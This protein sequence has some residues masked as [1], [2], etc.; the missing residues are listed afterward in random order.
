MNTNSTDFACLVTGFL[1]DYLPLQRSYS[2][3]TILSYRDTL[4]LFLRFLSE[5]KGISPGSFYVK[6]FRRELVIEFLEWYR[7][8]GASISAANQRLA[9]I[10][11][12]AGYAQFESIECIA[13]LQQVSGI[14]AKK[15][16]PREVTFI[17]VEQMSILINR[18]DINTY[19]GFRHRVIL[20]LLYDSGCRVQ[21]LCDITMADVALNTTSTVRLH[22][23]G[24]KYRTV[25][26]SDETAILLKNYI[27]R[28]MP[29]AVG[30]Q[31]LITNRFHQKIDRDGI[32][33]VIKK[34]TDLIHKEDPSFPEY[35]HCHMFRHSKAMHM[36]E[37]GINIIYIR[38]F[39]GHED[40]STTMVY[41]RA[42]NRLKN[43]A[44]N[45]LA[46]KVAGETNLP[47]WS[48]DKDLM[49]FLNSLK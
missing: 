6:D 41:V 25:V 44:I 4:K 30:T 8:T 16:S 32:A 2:S 19:T 12:F 40:I 27:Q 24:N 35:I 46:P 15:A 49:Q 29:D 37:A 31:P 43:D 47:D 1:T 22:G 48:K 28:Y 18:P 14:K 42:D 45:K 17:T 38:D 9:A 26:I 13:P 5:E 7:K 20:T 33:Y 11:T 34:Y 21:E 3:N 36:L 39:L 10:K 23:K